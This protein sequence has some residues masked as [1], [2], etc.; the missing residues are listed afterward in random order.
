M[1]LICLLYIRKQLQEDYTVYSAQD[2]EEGLE[3]LKTRGRSDHS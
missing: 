1:M 3:I 2:G